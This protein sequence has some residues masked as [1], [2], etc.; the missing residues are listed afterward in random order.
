[1]FEPP[2]PRAGGGSLYFFPPPLENFG[3]R[4]RTP[5]AWGAGTP[6]ATRSP[7]EKHHRLS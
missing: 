2:N 5:G 6:P 3:F 1:M 7:S 4:G